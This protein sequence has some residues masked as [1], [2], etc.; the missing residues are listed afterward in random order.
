MFDKMSCILQNLWLTQSQ[1]NLPAIHA[2]VVG[3]GIEGCYC[4]VDD[5]H[6]YVKD[7]DSDKALLHQVLQQLDNSVTLIIDK[8]EFGKKV[9][10]FLGYEVST[11]G[12][13]PTKE[14]VKIISTFP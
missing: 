4:F 7:E 5:I 3:R 2:R 6:L 8:C 9:I 10:N 1:L 11:T 13:K 14:R 12:I